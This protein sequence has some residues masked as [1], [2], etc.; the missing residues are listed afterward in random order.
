MFRER[1]GTPAS[2]GQPR[3]GTSDSNALVLDVSAEE[4]EKFLWVFYNPCVTHH[5]YH[6]VADSL[7]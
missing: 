5:L 3:Q 6:G 4:F 2:P 7:L 1:L